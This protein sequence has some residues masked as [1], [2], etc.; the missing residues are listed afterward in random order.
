MCGHGVISVTTALIELGMASPTE[1]D[2]AVVFDT[3]AGVVEGRRH[4]LA[5]RQLG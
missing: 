4:D 3:P 2:T 5:N 1:P